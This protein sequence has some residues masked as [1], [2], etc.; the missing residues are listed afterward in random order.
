MSDLSPIHEI[1][2]MAA[3][4]WQATALVLLCMMDNSPPEELIAL[5]DYHASAAD[6]EDYGALASERLTAAVV[7]DFAHI[8][9]DWATHKR[10]SSSLV[11][12]GSDPALGTD[13]RAGLARELWQI[14]LKI[15]QD[16]EALRTRVAS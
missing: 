1:T 9:D 10:L 11:H 8:E 3:R 14:A 6:F 2:Q 13:E 12:A 4:L 5:D 7:K 16:L 15:D